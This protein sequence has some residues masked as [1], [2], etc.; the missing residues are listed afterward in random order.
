[1]TGFW[2]K[3]MRDRWVGAFAASSKYVLRRVL[4]PLRPGYAS[5]LE[6]GP[7]DGIL[8][9]AL[10]PRLPPD[11]RLVAIERNPL[12]AEE[13]RRE[14][15]DP[16]VT[17]LSGD[18][19][20]YVHERAQSTPHE[21]DVVYSSIPLSFLS[22]E[23]RE[24]VISKASMLLQPGGVLIIFHQYSLLALPLLRKYFRTVEWHFEPRNVFPC[25]VM[26]AHP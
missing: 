5:F 19:V 11:G 14:I 6:L 17:I 12:F 21:V 18:A 9:R 1:M 22:P 24:R 7:G 26:I 25:F 20:Q 4:S 3:M 15:R 23:D 13:L 2:T 16:R 8:T 10:I